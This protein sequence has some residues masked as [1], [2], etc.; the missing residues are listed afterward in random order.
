MLPQ[1]IL[2]VMNVTLFSVS[3]QW[4]YL[5][6]DL[7]IFSLL[8][9]WTDRISP[10]PVKIPRYNFLPYVSFT[11]LFIY[12]FICLSMYLFIFNFQIHQGT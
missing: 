12:L 6:I 2:N 10:W 3:F 9:T 1:N 7:N 5:F 4:P 8:I 11:H